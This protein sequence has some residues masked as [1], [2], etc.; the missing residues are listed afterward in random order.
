MNLI[1]KMLKTYIVLNKKNEKN[2]KISNKRFN[3]KFRKILGEQLI[4]NIYNYNDYTFSN[5]TKQE[6]IIFIVLSNDETISDT[7]EYYITGIDYD[8][9]CFFL[10]KLDLRQCY[11]YIYIVSLID[12]RYYSQIEG[13]MCFKGL[14]QEIKKYKLNFKFNQFKNSTRNNTFLNFIE[15]YNIPT[16]NIILEKFAIMNYNYNLLENILK[17]KNIN[18]NDN[19]DKK[20]KDTLIHKIHKSNSKLERLRFEINQIV[21][22]KDFIQYMKNNKDNILYKELLHIKNDDLKLIYPKNLV[23]DNISINFFKNNKFNSAIPFYYQYRNYKIATKLLAESFINSFMTKTK[24][25]II[26]GKNVNKTDFGLYFPLFMNFRQS[27]E[28]AFKLIYVNESVKKNTKSLE[29]C[30]KEVSKHELLKLLEL[31]KPYLKK[32]INY[33]YL[34]FY[35]NLC[36]FITYFENEDASF[37]RYIINNKLDFNELGTIDMY[38]YDLYNYINEFYEIM[39]FTLSKINFGFKFDKIFT[40]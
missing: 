15:D 19:V 12:D 35:E 38:I 3:N 21:T 17:Y 8:Y 20:F 36:N 9:F 27:I 28:L 16:E 30:N 25:S 1:T 13:S 11:K 2:I 18:I 40:Q 7:N 29:D 14:C 23:A 39:D 4:N 33:Y 32:Y 34:K 6:E 26:D 10:Y 22:M 24:E 5:V 37:S 31:I